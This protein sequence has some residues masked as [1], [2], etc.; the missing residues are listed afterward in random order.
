MRG[1]AWPRRARRSVAQALAGPAARSAER[2][3]NRVRVM[4]P[5][6]RCT[7]GTVAVHFCREYALTKTP[8]RGRGRCAVSS[9]CLGGFASSAQ[10]ETGEAKIEAHC[11]S[12]DQRHARAVI[13]FGSITDP[14]AH[15][16]ELRAHC[17]GTI[18]GAC[19]RSQSS[20]ARGWDRCACRSPYAAKHPDSVAGCRCVRRCPPGPNQTGAFRCTEKQNGPRGA[21]R[22]DS[23]VAGACYRSKQYRCCGRLLWIYW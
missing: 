8:A 17:S 12:A 4:P 20:S 13:G 1:Q 3:G 6:W 15:D 11:V 16:R 5:E 21:V 7:L 22:F 9:E 14:Y 23:M 10:T 2:I 18:D 19:C